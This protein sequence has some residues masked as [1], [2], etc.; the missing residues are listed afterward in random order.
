M[1]CKPLCEV[2]NQV[3]FKEYLVNNLTE[4]LH[5]SVSGFIELVSIQY[6]ENLNTN[7]HPTPKHVIPTLCIDTVLLKGH[8]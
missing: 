3:L 4:W 1:H 6:E 7:H 2:I 5:T 8:H